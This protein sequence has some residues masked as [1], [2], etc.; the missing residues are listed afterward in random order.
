MFRIDDMKKLE[1]PMHCHSEAAGESQQVM[2]IFGRGHH[3]N[4]VVDLWR[5]CALPNSTRPN[6]QHWA[7]RDSQDTF[8]CRSQARTIC[9]AM[10]EGT[11]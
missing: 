2:I 1:P 6:R 11:H 4:D 5:G 3:A 8:S 7:M 10:A 9:G